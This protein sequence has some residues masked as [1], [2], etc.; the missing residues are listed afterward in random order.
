MGKGIVR[1][2]NPESLELWAQRIHD[3]ES[4][5]ETVSEWCCANSI[6]TKTYYY[7][8]RKINRF[9]N[10]PGPEFYQVNNNISAYSPG[11]SV[12]VHFGQISADIYSGADENTMSAVFRL[13]G[14]C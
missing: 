1:V 14:Q 6:N 10:S 11:V 13:L 5:G 7:W 2:R 8:H 4:S 9:E 3:C 12:T